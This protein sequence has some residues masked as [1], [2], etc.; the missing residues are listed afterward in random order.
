MSDFRKDENMRTPAIGNW[1]MPKDG[2]PPGI[3]VAV[4][5]SGKEC[6]LARRLPPDD[7]VV[8]TVHAAAD[9]QGPMTGKTATKPN[10]DL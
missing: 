2:N 6:V 10:H 4:L 1:L 3:V 9:L 5:P 7:R 8:E